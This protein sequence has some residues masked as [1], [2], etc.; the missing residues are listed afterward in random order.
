MNDKETSSTTMFNMGL[1]TTERIHNILTQLNDPIATQHPVI[2]TRILQ[3]LY[4]ELYPFLNDV[5]KV[6]GE[7]MRQDIYSMYDG[8]SVSLKVL[9]KMTAFEFWM[10]Q[11]LNDK[12]LLM[13]KSDDPGS[14]LGGG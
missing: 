3:S 7:R 10:R 4:M 12:G 14:A 6:E 9:S 2:R 11:K 1:A 5:E 13:A 8:D